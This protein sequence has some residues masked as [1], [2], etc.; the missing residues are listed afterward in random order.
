MANN[1]ARDITETT[2]KQLFTLSGNKCANPQCTNNLIH[3][4]GDTITVIAQIC[5]IEAA[6]V[7]GERYNENMN[8]D[9]RR[10]FNKGAIQNYAACFLKVFVMRKSLPLLYA[11]LNLIIASQPTSPHRCPLLFMRF[12]NTVR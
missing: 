3:I 2:I 7:G 8:D 12:C 9:E 1:K 5:H 10:H 11:T 4:D 6:N